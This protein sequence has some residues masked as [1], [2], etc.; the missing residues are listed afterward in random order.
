MN[1]KLYRCYMAMNQI[2]HSVTALC[3]V[4]EK[5]K[6][7]K[8]NLSALLINSKK[9]PYHIP[10]SLL[11]TSENNNEPGWMNYRLP[12]TLKNNSSALVH[13]KFWWPFKAL[14]SCFQHPQKL[15]NECTHGAVMSQ[16]SVGFS[17]SST[18]NQSPCSDVC[19]LCFKRSPSLATSFWLVS[20]TGFLRW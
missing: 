15:T 19:M 17:Q 12:Y 1:Y 13:S 16:P 7:K 3:H 18:L 4:H 10:Q 9:R 6:K 2:L 11:F 8:A 20:Q 14:L 5:R